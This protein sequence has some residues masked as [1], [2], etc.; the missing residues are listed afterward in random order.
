MAIE[1]NNTVLKP[2][3]WLHGNAFRTDGNVFRADGTTELFSQ[4]VDHAKHLNPDSTI[5]INGV[6]ALNKEVFNDSMADWIIETIKWFEKNSG[7]QLIIKSHPAEFFPG[8]PE[9]KETV[10]S[11]IQ[12]AF[13]KTP[14]NVFILSAKASISAYDLFPLSKVGLVFTT[15]IGME[16][17]AR[18]VPVITAGKSHYRGYGFTHDPS[19]KNEYFEL[20]KNILDDQEN[21]D[22]E[23]M[24]D[25]AMKFIKFN[26]FHYF[27]KTGLLEFSIGKAK[28]N[29]T[30]I[31]ITSLKELKKGS[32][33][34]FDYIVDCIEN[35]ES[36]LSEDKW[37]KES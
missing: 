33:I 20:L 37:M 22:K 36:I 31:K 23:K 26:F 32:I 28:K 16:M 35:G 12:K 13:E 17:A 19:T 8:I 25:L 30:H 27:T 7:Y 3:I 5:S 6:T 14:K 18:G 11:M 34:H 10:V 24:I 29:H 21:I 2:E 9:T 4:R 15:S 1:I